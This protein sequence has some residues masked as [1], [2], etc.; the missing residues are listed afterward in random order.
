M[1]YRLTVTRT[2]RDK[3]HHHHPLLHSL[4]LFLF[5]TWANGATSALNRKW[6]MAVSEAL[7]PH[8]SDDAGLQ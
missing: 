3:L 1:I 7:L 6:R 5:F 2:T 8:L 4:P